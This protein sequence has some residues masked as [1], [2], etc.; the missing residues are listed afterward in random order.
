MFKAEESVAS[1]NP[2]IQ[3]KTLWKSSLFVVDPQADFQE[4][5]DS[6]IQRY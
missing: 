5:T 4:A 2:Q 3:K 6:Y 1:S